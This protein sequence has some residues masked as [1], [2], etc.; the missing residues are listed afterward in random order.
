MEKADTVL[1]IYKKEDYNRRLYQALLSLPISLS[2]KVVMSW[3]TISQW[4]SFTFDLHTTTMISTS[5]VFK[6]FDNPSTLNQDPST[7]FYRR[8]REQSL[9][10]SFHQFWI[11]KTKMFLQPPCFFLFKEFSCLWQ[12]PI[13]DQ[14]FAVSFLYWLSCEKK[15]EIQI[16]LHGFFP[17]QT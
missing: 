14:C 16:I 7:P 9:P 4:T 12:S 1:L 11:E 15:L 10:F 3:S 2:L 5:Q 17:F 8:W 13:R 6:N